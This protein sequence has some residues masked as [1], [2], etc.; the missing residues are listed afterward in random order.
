MHAAALRL[1]LRIPDARS[2]KAK[3]SVLRPVLRRLR[4]RDL[5]VAEVD[6]QDDWQRA[7]VG[8]AVV[9]PQRGR[10]DEIVDGLQR[11]MLEDSTVELIEMGVSYLEEP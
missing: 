7:T 8:V 6:H 10:L 4:E 1:E 3:R 5:S 11:M 9:A 2:L